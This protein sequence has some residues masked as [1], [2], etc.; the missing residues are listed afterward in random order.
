MSAVVHSVTILNK[1]TRN[2]EEMLIGICFQIILDILRAQ[3]N[4]I[5]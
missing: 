4:V 3:Y 1:V 2:K 5:R